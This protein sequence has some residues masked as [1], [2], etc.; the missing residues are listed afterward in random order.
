M[1]ALK[2]SSLGYAECID[3][4]Y[5]T[6]G[7]HDLSYVSYEEEVGPFI[8]LQYSWPD[9]ELAG[10]EIYGLK[11]NFGEPPLK[12][13]VNAREPFTVEIPSLDLEAVA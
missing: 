3:H 2:P 10:M 4:L 1:K 6:F 12:I 9:N 8:T 5:V 11:K 13:A 7:E